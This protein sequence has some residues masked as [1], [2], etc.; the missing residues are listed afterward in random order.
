MADGKLPTGLIRLYALGYFYY[1]SIPCRAYLI[2][3]KDR[4]EGPARYN[5]WVLSENLSIYALFA[6][7]FIFR[8][9]GSKPRQYVVFKVLI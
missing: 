2:S 3:A 7:S 9:D 8:L 6:N 5:N 4:A 1:P